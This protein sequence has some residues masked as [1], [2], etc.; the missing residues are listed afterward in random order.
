VRQRQWQGLVTLVFVVVLVYSGLYLAREYSKVSTFVGMGDIWSFVDLSDRPPARFTEVS[1]EDFTGPPYAQVGDSLLEVNGLPA[2]AENYFSI[3]NTKTPAGTVIPIRF[4]RG[5]QILTGTVVT[6]SI[7]APL[8]IQVISLFVLRTIIT[9]AFILVGF[10]AFLRN[11][12]SSAVLT[13]A[14]FCFAIAVTMLQSRVGVSEEYARFRL[15]YQDLLVTAFTAFAL[16]TPALWLKLQLLFPRENLWYRGHRILAN[17]L[18]FLPVLL[19]GVLPAIDRFG[20]LLAVYRTVFVLLGSFLLLRNYFEAD[21]FVVRRQTRLVA[22]SS[23]PGLLLFCLFP[24]IPVLAGVWYATWSTL[25][26]L[27]FFNI[28]FLFLLLIPVVLAYSFGR[29]RLLEVEG[30]LKRGTRFVVVNVL[31]LVAF[32]AILY[33]FAEFLL[34][35]FQVESRAPTLVVGL[36]LALGLVPAQRRARSF[37]EER[38]YPEREKLRTLLREF[39]Q[40]AGGRAAEARAFWEEL[41]RRLSVGLSTKTVYPVLR[42]GNS[43]ALL[44]DEGRETPVAFWMKLMENLGGADYPLLLD[45]LVE[46][47]RIELDEN[48]RSWFQSAKTAVLLPLATQSGPLGFLFIGQKENGEDYSPEELDLLRS[49]GAQIALVAENIELLQEKLEKQK[50]QEQMA[51]AREIQRGLLPEKLPETPGIRVAGRIRFCLDVAGDYYDVL[52][53]GDGRTLVAVGDVAGK[54]VG[55]ALLMSNLQAS[56]RAVQGVGVTLPEV[57]ARI[58]RLICENTPPEMFITLFVAIVDPQG[59]TVS[60]VNAGHNY[61]VLCRGSGEIVRLSEGGLLLGIY[62]E[63]IFEEGKAD[64]RSGETLLMFTDGVSEATNDTDEEFGEERIA[65]ILRSERCE[66]LEEVLENLEGAVRRFRGRETFEDDFTLLA[67]SPV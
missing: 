23:A 40:T 37:L 44:L 32:F 30:R 17:V 7:P 34:N 18:I 36:V 46:S 5:D 62:P 31:F 25:E 64:L 2:T 58:N 20:L 15:P 41:A 49:L 21:S 54:G 61:P 4:K 29:Y 6:R 3:F 27:Y 22:I 65:E 35:N 42:R 50:L 56:L 13:L 1:R 33:A 39:L 51:V 63:A 67:V 10:W 14:F 53:L 11:S 45:E 9:L 8:K 26:N 12:R 28:Y 52:P 47:G 24:W 16:L 43:V 57:M 59:K 19:L 48:Q 38:F 66:H 60:Y 55:A